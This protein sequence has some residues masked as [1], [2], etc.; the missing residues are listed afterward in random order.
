MHPYTV[1]CAC[2]CCIV[3]V[4][5]C[6]I[7]KREP[8]TQK[9]QHTHTHKAVT[10]GVEA[11]MLLSR[12][13]Q[14]DYRL[15]GTSLLFVDAEELEYLNLVTLW[16]GHEITAYFKLGGVCLITSPPCGETLGF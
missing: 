12:R 7:V 3:C 14:S 15:C 8:R 9:M 4:C 11:K 13:S 5:D 16:N 6:V 10:E 2:A 1:L